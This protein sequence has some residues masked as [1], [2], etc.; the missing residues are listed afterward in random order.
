MPD[1][2]LREL[3]LPERSAQQV[4]HWFKQHRGIEIVI[5]PVPVNPWRRSAVVEH[6]LLEGAVADAHIGGSH[7]QHRYLK[8]LKRNRSAIGA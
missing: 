3:L 8:Q 6:P 5:R 7:R 4:E 1:A 2:C